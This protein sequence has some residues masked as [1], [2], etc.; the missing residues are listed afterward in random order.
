MRHLQAVLVT[1][2]EVRDCILLKSERLSRQ[3]TAMI[4]AD[5]GLKVF[6]VES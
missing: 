6:G 1:G 2:L 3:L 5:I 4:V